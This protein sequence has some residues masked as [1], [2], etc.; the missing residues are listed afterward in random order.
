MYLFGLGVLCQW[1]SQRPFDLRD[2]ELQ[3]DLLKKTRKA[4]LRFKVK[5]SFSGVSFPTVFQR[6]GKG[7]QGLDQC[8]P[9]KSPVAFCLFLKGFSQVK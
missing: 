4:P 9:S 2:P 3:K 6:N 7:W 1:P 5:A 8:L